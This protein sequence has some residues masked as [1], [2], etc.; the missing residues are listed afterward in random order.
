MI[1]KM[2]VKMTGIILCNPGTTH[3]VFFF[4]VTLKQQLHTLD[5]TLPPKN[6]PKPVHS[7]DSESTELRYHFR[8]NWQRN[9]SNKPTANSY[10]H[11]RI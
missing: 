10:N 8:N 2:W 1:N 5:K 3:T 6:G 7:S 4:C 9:R 11:K